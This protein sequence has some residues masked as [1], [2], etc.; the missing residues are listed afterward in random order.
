M[1]RAL[2][3]LMAAALLLVGLTVP[4]SA[5]ADEPISAAGD[6]QVVWDPQPTVARIGPGL[7]L[8]LT[9]ATHL[10]DQ[11]GLPMAGARVRFT[12]FQKAPGLYETPKRT[13]LFEVCDA[14]ADAN[15]FATCKGNVKALLGSVLSLLAGGGYATL[16]IGPF[17]S[18][19]E[20]T[21]LPVII[22]N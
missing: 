2:T 4:S 8:T 5:Q 21:K 18:E 13:L 11:G 14:V 20:F 10:H 12:L 1:S 17:P 16:L 9:F 7:N 15:G 3:L 19:D 22:S 6:P